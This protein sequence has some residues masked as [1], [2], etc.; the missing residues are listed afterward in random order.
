MLQQAMAAHEGDGFSALASISGD[1]KTIF[2]VNPE[3]ECYKAWLGI[4]AP[5]SVKWWH[6]SWVH[7]EA[8]TPIPAD[9]DNTDFFYCS[10][11]FLWRE[12]PCFIMVELHLANIPE[13][14]SNLSS[15]GNP[16]AVQLLLN[17]MMARQKSR[18]SFLHLPRL[19][20]ETKSTDPRGEAY[21]LHCIWQEMS[22]E[23][24]FLLTIRSQ[25][26]RFLLMWQEFI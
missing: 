7:Q 24:I 23:G 18:R 14:V 20:R 11:S 12:I 15:M 3:S 8:S 10:F 9:R 16:V 4:L 17:F 21:L 22:A 25:C 19:S 5:W 13:V 2:Y 26:L 1:D 6:R